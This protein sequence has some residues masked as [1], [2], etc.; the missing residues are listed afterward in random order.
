MLP[1]LTLGLLIMG[2]RI[3]MRRHWRLQK[4]QEGGDDEMTLIHFQNEAK[5]EALVR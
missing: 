4:N 5:L 1:H 2:W 3:W